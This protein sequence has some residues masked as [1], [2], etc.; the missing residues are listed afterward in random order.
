MPLPNAIDTPGYQFNADRIDFVKFQPDGSVLLHIGPNVVAIGG[1]EG[2][3]LRD[4]LSPPK[5]EPASAAATK[6]A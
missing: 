2:A 1:E 6:K 3:K 4:L 5:P